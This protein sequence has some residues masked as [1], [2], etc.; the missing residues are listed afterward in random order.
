MAELTRT[1]L[2]PA[3]IYE[4]AAQKGEVKANASLRYM[5][6]LGFLGGAFIAVGFLFCIKVASTFPKEWAGLGGVIGAAV[7]PVGL[8]LILIGGG[9][10]VT[11]NMMAVT[12]GFL[13]KRVSLAKLGKN[14]VIITL[15]NLVGSIFVAYFLGHVTGLSEGSVLPKTIAVAQAKVDA[16]FWKAFFEGVGCNWLVG[17]AVW[18]SF[19]AKDLTGKFLGTYFPVF[20][21]VAIGFQHLVANMYVIPAAIFGGA[22]ITWMQFANNMAVIF[23]GN[24]VGAVTLVAGLYTLAYKKK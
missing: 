4:T 19:C 22:N 17:M 8:I 9:E 16:T 12:V 5:L 6:S 14:M 10:L 15:A 2:E 20:T 7:F 11:G 18:L 13:N 1:A 21:F 3:E 24:F 23:L